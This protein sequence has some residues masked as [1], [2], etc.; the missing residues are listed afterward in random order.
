MEIVTMTAERVDAAAELAQ[1]LWPDAESLA[2]EFRAALNEDGFVVFLAYEGQQPVGFAQCQLRRD[3]VEGCHTSP[4]GYLEGVF[5]SEEH[6]GK[7]IA[8]TLLAG[9][10]AWARKQGCAEFAS[11]CELTNVQSIAFHKK[12]GFDEENRIVCFRKDL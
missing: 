9:C 2:D 11:D 6:R 8:K 7:G 5:V 12:V 1:Q 4:V 3:Y 10:E